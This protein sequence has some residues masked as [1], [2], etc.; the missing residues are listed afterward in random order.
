M[1][2]SII[3]I[4]TDTT[5]LSTAVKLDLPVDQEVVGESLSGVLCA[6]FT[7]WSATNSKS[8]AIA[9]ALI[10]TKS[11]ASLRL[12]RYE[13]ATITASTTGR[14][15]GLDNASGDYLY[16]IAFKDGSS[17]LD[18]TGSRATYSI[19]T[20]TGETGIGSACQWYLQ[21]VSDTGS[22]GYSIVVQPTR[23]S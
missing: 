19:Q 17:V 4:T 22:D 3:T 8:G 15:R 6:S 9:L 7:A 11:S 14:R 2:F 13:E 18:L 20:T 23:G 21:L 5:D 10:D 12:I 1:S 16:E